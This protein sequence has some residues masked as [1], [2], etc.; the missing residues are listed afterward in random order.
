MNDKVL[1][2]AGETGLTITVW[3]QD[4]VS[5]ALKT[6]VTVT[7]LDSRYIRIETDNDVTISAADDVAELADLDAAHTDGDMFEVDKAGTPVGAYRFDVPDAAV[8]AGAD[9]AQIYIWDAASATILPC[10]VEIEL[11]LHADLNT[12]M[13]TA[14]SDI[15]LHKLMKT[16]IAGPNLTTSDVASDSVLAHIISKSAGTD[17]TAFRNTTDSLEAIK[18][19]QQGACQAA[20]ETNNLDHLMKVACTATDVVDTSALAY[21][22]ADGGDWSDFL[23]GSYSLEDIKNGQATAL[24]DINLHKLMYYACASGDVKNNS[25]LAQIAAKTQHWSD[26]D[27]ST[28]SLQA[29]RDTSSTGSAV[30]EITD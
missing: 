9:R 5:G 28:D 16:A 6:G 3:L 14:L 20:I 26:F 25:A 17:V 19:A 18:D 21:I 7:D 22:A 11:N 4:A 2:K 12:E 13:D 29:I 27:Y 1:H 23:G 15:N 8:A 10:V 24:S 30:P